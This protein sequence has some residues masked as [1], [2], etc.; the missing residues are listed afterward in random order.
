MISLSFVD[1]V[2]GIERQSQ[3]EMAL[4]KFMLSKKPF[5]VIKSG[6][7]KRAATQVNAF[8]NHIARHG[9]PVSAKLRGDEVY[10]INCKL[11]GA[12]QNGIED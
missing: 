1:S 4:K 12:K 2:P 7:R 6:S 5:A 11:E 10:L 9:Y 8:K 3:Y